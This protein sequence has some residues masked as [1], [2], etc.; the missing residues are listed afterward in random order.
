MFFLCFLLGGQNFEISMLVFLLMTI[1]ASGAGAV[2]DSWGLED[3]LSSENANWGHKAPLNPASSSD[4]LSSDG[5]SSAAS[6][7]ALMAAREE[8][9]RRQ[10][11]A[12]LKH[13]LKRARGVKRRLG[14]GD[15]AGAKRGLVRLKHGLERAMRDLSK[16]KHKQKRENKQPRL[17]IG[18]DPADDEFYF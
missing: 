9:T 7:L 17:A 18:D 16:K 14:R 1:A 5:L 6:Q 15:H 11:Q 2:A 13:L 8:K 3:A 4:G 12:L 10:V